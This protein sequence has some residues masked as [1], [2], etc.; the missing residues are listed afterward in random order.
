MFI[1]VTSYATDENV[2]P[3]LVT[4]ELSGSQID[5]ASGEH[6]IA[7]AEVRQGFSPIIYAEVWARIDR[8]DFTGNS[9][10]PVD[11]QLFDN[12]AGKCHYTDVQIR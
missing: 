4:S 8:P 11:V 10:P 2:E 1:T 9:Y 12:G 3:I 6:I 7:Y 5:V